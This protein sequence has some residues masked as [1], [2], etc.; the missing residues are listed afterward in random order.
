MSFSYAHCLRPGTYVNTVDGGTSGVVAGVSSLAPAGVGHTYIVRLDQRTS[1]VWKAYPYECAAIPRSLLR[2]HGTD[3]LVASYEGDVQFYEQDQKTPMVAKAQDVRR[4][5]YEPYT[6]NFSFKD[7]DSDT[8]VVEASMRSGVWEGHYEMF[9]EGTTRPLYHGTLYHIVVEDRQ[10]T[11]ILNASMEEAG[12][13][14]H[15]TL[16]AKCVGE[17]AEVEEGEDA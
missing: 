7:D 13:P 3:N 1:E 15:I 8:Y 11:L 17:K 5:L 2:V 10:G 4:K 6:L 9:D 14:Q 16:R 12:N